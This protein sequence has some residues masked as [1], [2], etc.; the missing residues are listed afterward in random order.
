LGERVGETVGYRVRLDSQVSARTRV[1][2]VTEGILTRRLQSDPELRGVGLV[3]FDEFHERSLN[4]DLGLALCLETQSVLR[5]DLRILVMSATLDTGALAAMLAAPVIASQGRSFP[6]DTRYIV[7]PARQALEQTVAAAVRTALAEET[8]S[9]LVFLPGA[10]EIGRVQRLL[11]PLAGAGLIVAPLYGDLARAEQDQAVQALPA[12]IRMVV[13]ATSIA[14]TSLTIEGIRVVIDSGWSRVSRF[15]PGSGMTRLETIP[16]SQAAA[17]QRRGRAGRLGPGVCYRLWSTSATLVP[18]TKP[19]ILE[20]D[21]APLALQLANWGVNDPASLRWLDPPP[22]A[23]YTQAYDLIKVLEGIDKS[24]RITAY[25][26]EMAALPVHP[27][28]AHMMIKA[29]PLGL[30]YT[31]CALAALLTERDVLKGRDRDPDFALRLR[32][33]AGDAHEG[34]GGTL[35]GGALRQIKNLTAQLARLIDF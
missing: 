32:L 16:V 15:A 33:L 22:A 26:R 9:L 3:I 19:E 5:E 18:Y 4:A 6:V 10:A 11:E 27:R 35:D 8:G 25:G 13:L 29:K 31:A 20:T 14:E 12:G 21:L 7:P 34:A 23:A 28:L 24:G 30:A 2:L 17:D 1:E